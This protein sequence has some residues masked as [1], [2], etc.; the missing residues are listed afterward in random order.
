[1]PRKNQ[2]AKHL[3]PAGIIV[4]SAV[5]ALG[6]T[7]CSDGDADSVSTCVSTEQY[8]AENIW[9]PILSQKCIACH[10]VTG[11]AKDSGFLLDNASVAG[12][13]DKNLGM[14]R[15]VA[16][17]KRDGE[18]LILLK[19]TNT[20][21][22]GGGVQIEKGGA[23]YAAMKGLLARFDNPV[24]CGDTS[25]AAFADVEMLGW[26]L[27]GRKAALALGGRL[28]TAEEMATIEA[29][30][31]AGLDTLL[32]SLMNE[33][34][35][36]ERLKQI[37]NDQFLTDQYLVTDDN[38][39]EVLPDPMEGEQN[40]YNPFWFENTAYDA[41]LMEKMGAS[42]PGDLNNKLEGATRLGVAREA[43]E[44]IAYVVR[45]N[46]P[47]T[48][49]LTA[50]YTVVNPFSAKAYGITDVQF[51]NDADPNEFQ[52]A[53]FGGY[54]GNFPHAGVLTSPIMLIRHPTTPTNVNR[55]RAR[56]VYQWFL[57]TDILKT[58]EQPLDPTKIT[59]F[60]P[61]M[62]NAACTV[63]HAQI[64]GPAGAFHSF[65]EVGRFIPGD[66][67]NDNMR[68]PGFGGELVPF[69]QFDQSIQWLGDKV[70]K[71][72][73]FA[74]SAVYIMFEGITGQKP[75]IAPKDAKADGFKQE[76][77][78]YLA[79]YHAFNNI[80]KQ[81]IE[82]GYNLK[83][84][85]AA[86]IKSPYFRAVNANTTDDTRRAE[87]ANLGTGQWVIPEQLQRKILAVT[88]YPFE[89]ND[90]RGQL[91]ITQRGNNAEYGEYFTLYGGID[92]KD[93]TTRTRDPNG[94]M[95]N[96]ADRMANEMACLSVPRDF[97][98]AQDKRRYFP[99]VDPT[100]APKDANGFEVVPAVAAIKQN[101]Q[102]LHKYILGED[103]QEGSAELERTYKLFVALWDDG[104]KGM[105]IPEGTEG[106]YSGSLP[107]PCQVQ[108]DFWL[109]RSS[110][111]EVPD[112]PEDQQMRED[113]NYTVRA[114]MGVVTYM[115]SDAKF[116]YE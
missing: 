60:N 68:P 27:T 73:R 70:S 17:L 9:A 86:L 90:R 21:N 42:S 103:L 85:V 94:V 63:C 53:Y 54:G 3:A 26:G 25:A 23:E 32:G 99:F 49:I 98:L 29:S 64:D 106:H 95:A 34:V 22:H 37:Y 108:K 97:T 44:L 66:K 14:V 48:E 55:H 93:T 16:S 36:Y 46:L 87:L 41:S 12:F 33:E 50:P 65:D 101:I 57:G 79:Q 52:K 59:D 67:W 13:L 82:S 80:S 56:M 74:L 112:L 15:E 75:L 113:A 76:F 83:H 2:L 28:P 43:V 19:P 51:T 110:N 11:A 102:Y 4:A 40:Y 38:A 62:N 39:L 7:G 1:M 69:D 35:F 8:F 100:F 10:N 91:V 88:G 105:A 18:S 78:S 116:L 107:G 24:D 104:Q 111:G 6:F 77:A 96:I 109:D 31:E 115:L 81:F 72:P 92:S 47:F 20:I 58:A 30:G 89:D 61:T 114:W 45:N 71:D 5:A 84:L